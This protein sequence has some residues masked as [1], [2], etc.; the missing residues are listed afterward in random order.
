MNQKLSTSHPQYAHLIAYFPFDEGSGTVLMDYS[1]ESCTRNQGKL[2]N[3]TA[4]TASN[5]PIIADGIPTLSEWGLIVLG[6]LLMI[7][8]VLGILQRE[9]GVGL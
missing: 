7:F 2:V 6:L 8:G 1:N 9:V 4:F 5:A 3:G